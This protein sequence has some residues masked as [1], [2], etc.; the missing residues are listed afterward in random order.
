[1]LLR[2]DQKA[3]KVRKE[4]SLKSMLLISI[5][6]F[7]KKHALMIYLFAFENIRQTAF[8]SSFTLLADTLC[9]LTAAISTVK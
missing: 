1:M 8:T 6:L 7:F 2:S 5:K 4:N 3:K 9:R